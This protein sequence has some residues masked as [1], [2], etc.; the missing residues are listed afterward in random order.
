MTELAQI[1]QLAEQKGGERIAQARERGREARAGFRDRLTKAREAAQTLFS[2]TKDTASAISNKAGEIGRIAVGFTDKEV[3]GAV[4]A[5]AGERFDAA[6]DRVRQ[7]G[8]EIHTAFNNKRE[9]AVNAITTRVGELATAVNERVLQPAQQKAGEIR[10]TAVNGAKEGTLFA[11]GVARTAAE[12]VGKVA[13]VAGTGAVRA[14]ELGVDAARRGAQ[15]ARETGAAA[16]ARGAETAQG[17]Y[18]AA[19]AAGERAYQGGVRRYET[20]REQFRQTKERAEAT[21]R[22]WGGRL[23]EFYEKQVDRV[24]AGIHRG[25]AEVANAWHAVQATPAETRAAVRGGL[26]RVEGGIAAVTGRGAETIFKVVKGVAEGSRQR[27]EANR[28]RSLALRQQAGKIRLN[29]SAR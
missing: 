20:G 1:A 14:G 13:V 2:K 25:R 22:R 28:E 17:V 7:K 19:T 15:Y 8:R 9:A 11:V 21:A 24:Q 18:R 27:A 10:K 16:V 4:V 29:G 3:R 6:E 12:T 5:Y 23:N 26:A